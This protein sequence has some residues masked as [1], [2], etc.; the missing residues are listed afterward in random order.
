MRVSDLHLS[1]PLFLFSLIFTSSYLIKPIVSF[2]VKFS[3]ECRK[4]K[5]IHVTNQDKSLHGYWPIRTQ[6]ENK[7]TA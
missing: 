7:P 1:S 5:V 6:G 4:T 2:I 3:I